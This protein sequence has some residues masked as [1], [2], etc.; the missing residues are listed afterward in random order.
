MGRRNRFVKPETIRIDISDGDWIEIKKTLN[1]GEMK[2]LETVGLKPATIIDGK[3]FQ[4]IDWEVHDIE[5]CMVFLTGWSIH[6]ENDKPVEV[7]AASL[8]AMDPESFS[9]IN[10]AIMKHVLDTVKE[11]NA[12][13]ESQLK[14]QTTPT[15]ETPTN[16]ETGTTTSS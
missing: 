9:E 3:F 2:R 1:N 12:A 15:S 6:D 5:R 13:R 8:R 11:K 4:P 10:S 16:S 14:T 7:S